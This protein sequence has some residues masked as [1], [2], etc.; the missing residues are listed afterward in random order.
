V[1]STATLSIEE[2]NQIACDNVRLVHAVV[3]RFSD[4][5]NRERRK[6]L[7]QAGFIG[8]L[9]AI[10]NYDPGPDPERPK[11]L[12]TFA[13]S[14]I[15]GYVLA[16]IRHLS[17]TIHVSFDDYKLLK[18]IQKAEREVDAKRLTSAQLQRHVCKELQISARKY[19]SLMSAEQINQRFTGSEVETHNQWSDE[20][21][22]VTIE[23]LVEDEVLTNGRFVQAMCLVRILMRDLDPQDVEMMNLHIMKNWNRYYTYARIAKIYEVSEKTVQRKIQKVFDHVR[24]RLLDLDITLEDLMLPERYFIWRKYLNKNFFENMSKK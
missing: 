16:Q 19:Q 22:S 21:Q 7:F 12:S 15:R 1:I 9:I 2:R 14:H 4:N 10:E 23:D 13:Y 5:F 18:K 24:D 20:E 8:L 17:T 11:R 6:D 3:A